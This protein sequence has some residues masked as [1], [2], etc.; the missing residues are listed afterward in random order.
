MTNQK[1]WGLWMKTKTISRKNMMLFI[2][3]C[4]IVLIL[5]F[6]VLS[7]NQVYAQTLNN[8][9]A[10]KPTLTITNTPTISVITTSSQSSS[11]DDQDNE[12]DILKAQIEIIST[13]SDRLTNVFIG[14]GGIII[15]LIAIFFGINLYM[16]NRQYEKDMEK[17]KLEINNSINQQINVEFSKNQSRID[18]SIDRKFHSIEQSLISLQ[19][20]Q[21]N[22]E[23]DEWA[24][25]GVVA[26]EI[27]RYIEI[28]TLDPNDICMNFTLDKLINALE[29]EQVLLSSDDIGNLANALSK[30]DKKFES[31]SQHILEL[32]RTKIKIIT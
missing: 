10:V 1:D 9:N 25:K 13:Y 24:K 30:I 7:K 14:T 3:A 20:D 23:A 16:T 5:S 6:L 21:L 19:K 29:K 31:V 22:M 15:T 2:F 28:I 11:S 17:I 32:A 18:S 26:N 27:G 12:I 4:A 8:K